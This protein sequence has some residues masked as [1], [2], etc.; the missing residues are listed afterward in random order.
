MQIQLRIFNHF[1]CKYGSN[2]LASVTESSDRDVFFYSVKSEKALEPCEN[3]DLSIV[4]YWKQI[5]DAP[6]NSI[7]NQIVTKIIHRRTGALQFAMHKAP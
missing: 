4:V 7:V 6:L 5:I 3:I 1:T 2:H